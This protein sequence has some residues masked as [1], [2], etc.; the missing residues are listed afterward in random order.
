MTV[1]TR[2]LPAERGG[3]KQA[4]EIVTRSPAETAAAG[5]VLASYLQD[6]DLVLLH[7]D[8]GAGKTTLAK[9]I[10][11]ALGIEDVVSS[12]SFSLVNEFDTGQTAAPSR[13]YHLDLYRLRDEND[14]AS[15]GFDDL[16]ASADGVVLVEWPERAATILPERY[17]LI[18][19]ETAGSDARR[20]RFVPGTNNDD[21]MERIE[22]LRSHLAASPD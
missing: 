10:A 8:L 14:L 5:E 1:G 4:W 21:W 17:L 16:V 9:G 15:I 12:P 2:P 11:A 22:R 7:G 13:L 3:T 20:L 18:E 6:G 19:L